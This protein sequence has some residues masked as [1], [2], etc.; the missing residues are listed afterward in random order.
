MPPKSN[1]KLHVHVLSKTV[2]VSCGLGTQ[3]LRWL[4]SVAISRWD[5]GSFEGWRYLGVP[6]KMIDGKGKELDMGGTIRDLF[7]DGDEITVETSILPES[8]SARTGH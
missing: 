5:E 6:V 8:V 1:I 7:E 3:R 4:G 2:V